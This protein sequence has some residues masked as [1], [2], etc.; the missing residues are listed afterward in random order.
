MLGSR[1][2]R[3]GTSPV[4]SPPLGWVFDG[5]WS[6]GVLFEKFSWCNKSGDFRI[7]GIPICTVALGACVCNMQGVLR[8][9]TLLF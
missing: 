1:A 9:A 6:C 5:I 2:N 8:T 7:N 4:P 3:E